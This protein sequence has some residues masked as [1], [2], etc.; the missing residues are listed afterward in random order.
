MTLRFEPTEEL[1]LSA[2]SLV[3]FPLLCCAHSLRPV[4]A[5]RRLWDRAPLDKEITKLAKGEVL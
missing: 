5:A 3:D 2:D 1:V 4:F